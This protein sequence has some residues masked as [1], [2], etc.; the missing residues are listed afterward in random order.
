MYDKLIV[1]PQRGWIALISALVLAVIHQ[2]LFYGHSFGISYPVFVILFYLYMYTY[3]GDRLRQGSWFSRLVMVVILLLSCT[4]GLFANEFFRVLNGLFIP[5]LIFLHLAYML[6]RRRLDWNRPALIIDALDHL[7]PQTFRHFVTPFKMLKNKASQ[8]MQENQRTVFRK[9][10]LGVLT[11]LP[12]LFII[13]ALLTSADRMFSELLGAMPRWMMNLS[14][15]EGTFR[16]VW[17]VIMGFILFGYLW[18]FVKPFVYAPPV[19]QTPPP[20]AASFTP[21]SGLPAAGSA[22]AVPVH[23]H[24]ADQASEPVLSSGAHSHSK[25]TTVG[26]ASMG[27]P[28]PAEH[29]NT[30]ASVHQSTALPVHTV[31]PVRIDPIILGTVLVLINMVYVLF[32]VLQFSY[33]FG[34]P[35]GNLPDG[36]TYA[37]YA[38]SGFAE[39]VLVTA[40]NFVIMLCGLLYAGP[41]GRGLMRLNNGL[42]YVLVL[43]SGVMLYSAFTRLLLYEQAYGYTTIRFL[44]HAFM[45]FLGVLLIVAGLRIHFRRLP[46][47]RC[48]IILALAAYVLVN[49][50]GMDRQIASRNIERYEQTGQLDM[51]YLTSLSADAVPELL[52]FSRQHEVPGLAAGLHEHWAYLFDQDEGWQSINLSNYL[53]IRALRQDNQR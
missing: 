6:S 22:Q 46:L 14:P 52:T 3:A 30:G 7:I 24:Q 43:C 29:R 31:K 36:S 21:S 42:L 48:Y 1:V 12:L 4:Y 2:Y 5:C 8:R 50:A 13:I 15:G 18:G 23:G 39:L 47:A 44:V 26:N 49:Y 28:A 35:Q 33:L 38:R 53:A 37:E 25:N 40:L 16:L 45:I 20:G 32:V 11:A 17:V 34:A 27:A 9:I 10:M 51:D 41:A 19:W